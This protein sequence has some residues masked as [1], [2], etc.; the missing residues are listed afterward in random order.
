[1]ALFVLATAILQ[2]QA[3]NPVP[4]FIQ[5]LSGQFPLPADF[6]FEQQIQVGMQGNS[7]DGNPFAYGHAL[8]FRPWLHYDGIPNTTF[9]GSVSYIY[10]FT[11]P[12]TSYYRHAEWRDT[13]MGTLKQPLHGGSL[14]EEIRGELLNFHDS[15][16]MVQ[17]LPRVRFRFGQNLYLGE[18]GSKLR[19]AYLGLYQDAILQF[20][21]PSYSHV[22]F[23]SARFFAGGGFELGSRTEVLLGFKAEGEVSSSGSKVTMFFGPAFSIEYNFRGRR[24]VHDNHQRTTAFRD[25]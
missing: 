24:R 3:L 6:S 23:T 14:Y 13:L 4:G 22:T 21:R 9:T 10:Y 20:P 18:G 11:V 7:L 16:G 5:D 8:Q 2:G 17:H 1:M 25:F 19:K 15:H 12:G